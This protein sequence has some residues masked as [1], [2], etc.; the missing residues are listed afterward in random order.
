MSLE[1]SKPAPEQRRPGRTFDLYVA[2]EVLFPALFGLFGLT[3]VVLTA[4]L[5]DLSDLFINR[6]VSGGTVAR[7]LFFEGVPVA[8][9]MLPFAVL[10]GSLVAL[11]RL[12]ADRE[13]L[14]LE[15]SGVSAVR[16]SWPVVLLGACASCVSLLLS[17]SATPW[18]GRRFEDTLADIARTKPWA[19]LEAGRR[20]SFGGWQ[21]DA[22]EVS[23]EGTQLQSVMLWVPELGE[24]IFSRR[25][26]LG[27]AADGGVEITLREGRLVFSPNPDGSVNEIN[28]DVATTRLPED[29]SALEQKD[30]DRI[31]NLPMDELRELA[32]TFVPTPTDVLPRAALEIQRRYSYPAASLVFGLLAVPV[33]LTRRRLSRS[34][35]GVIGL[36]LTLAYYGLVQVGEGLVAAGSVG[37]GLGAWFPNL[38]LGAAALA[39]LVRTRRDRTL[40]RGS[41]GARMVRRSSAASA[42]RRGRPHRYALHRYVA[43]RALQLLAL[44]FAVLFTAYFLIDLMDRLSWFSKYQATPL[45]IVRFYGA[46]IWLLVSRAVPMAILVGTAL[47]VSLLAAEGELLGMRA[48]GI[49]APRALL[50]A[51][52]IAALLAPAYFVLNNVVLPRSQ[53]L[54]DE[55]KH[56][57][58]KAQVYAEQQERRKVGYRARTGNQFVEAGL[59]DP[60]LGQARKITIFEMGPD[61]LPT[62]RTD[63]ASGRHIGEGWWRLTDPERVE[64]GP[65]RVE[66]V[67]APRHAQLGDTVDAGVDTDHLSARQIALEA[68]QVE[69]DGFPA[70]HYWVEF[71]K[72]LAEPFG[73]LVLPALVLF[74]AAGGPP[75]PTPAQTLLVS[76]VIGVCYVLLVA[77]SSSLGRGGALPPVV[78]A[79]AP[80]G[81]FATLMLGAATR[82]LRRL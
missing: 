56:T 74:F 16:L 43:G 55:L 46:R 41:E 51:L 75:F 23:A 52:L 57:E 33:F 19:H 73:C 60:D 80:I 67:P 50:P 78:S 34:S 65:Q 14:A 22:R 27:P 45:E 24:T 11:G 81:V 6:G 40:S 82:L 32:A 72:R 42:A 13:I 2:R 68:A 48:C 62:S 66:R 7:M 25:G 20:A 12:A 63:A 26:S 29:T 76:A 47:T 59:F 39:L 1:A 54:A 37:P 58:I 49:P 17:L 44:S 71:H 30:K 38:V 53:A 28:F 61:G 79:W 70:T 10:V 9:R 77:V 8:A 4:T 36:L 15:A 18:A 3:A 64:L 31:P 21:L 5:L 69:A 35:G